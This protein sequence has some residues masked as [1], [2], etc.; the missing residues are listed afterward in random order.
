MKSL[1]ELTKSALYCTCKRINY[2]RSNLKLKFEKNCF[3]IEREVRKLEIWLHVKLLF[4]AYGKLVQKLL[5]RKLQTYE[6]NKYVGTS[7]LS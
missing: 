6:T 5:N 2:V 4:A 7:K 3:I 1:Q